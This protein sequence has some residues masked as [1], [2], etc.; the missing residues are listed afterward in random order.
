MPAV[1]NAANE[2]AVQA[3]LEGRIPFHAISSIIEQTLDEMQ[4]SHVTTVVDLATIA[5]ADSEAR[6][7]A[8]AQ[9]LASTFSG[10]GAS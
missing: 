2:V 3:F 6:R 4:K 7:I 9:G 8:E 1:L 5:A 10:D